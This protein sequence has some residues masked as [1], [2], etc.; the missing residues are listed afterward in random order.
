MKFLLAVTAVTIAILYL[1][2]W[3][4]IAVVAAFVIFNHG[5]LL[6]LWFGFLTWLALWTSYHILFVLIGFHLA[7]MTI[8][9][10]NAFYG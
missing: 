2:R 1:L 10:R 3:F 6:G 8:Q 5:L 7:T 4:I 9:K